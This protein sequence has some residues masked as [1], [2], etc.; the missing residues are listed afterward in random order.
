MYYV[1]IEDTYDV[2]KRAHIATGHGGRDQ[3]VREIGKKYVNVTRDAIEL[4]KSYRYECQKKHKRPRTKGVVVRPTLTN[5]FASRAQV[6]LID[7]QSMSQHAFKWILVY[8]DH[9]TKFVI[10]RA[11]TSKRAAEV[12]HN[13]LDIFLLIGAPSILQS[14]NGTEFTAEVITELKLFW[15]RLVMVHGKPRH[16]QS[17]GSVERAN[18]DIK[19][20]LVAWMGDNDTNDWSIGIKFVQFQKNSSFHSGIGRAPHTAMFGCD[21]KVGLATSSLPQEIIQRMQTEDDL[22]AAINAEQPIDLQDDSAAV[23]NDEVLPAAADEQIL[24]SGVPIPIEDDPVLTEDEHPANLIASRI[25]MIRT[26]RSASRSAQLQ[27]AE[28]MVKRSRLELAAGMP[29]DNV[30]IPIPLVDRGRG[31]PRNILGVIVDRDQ[32]DMYKISVK[33]GMLKARFS[34]NQFDLC[35]QKLLKESDV[36]CTQEVSLRQAVTK[37]SK[38]GGQGLFVAIVPG[39][40]VVKVIV[41]SATKAR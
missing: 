6:D 33:S 8:Q 11:L 41:V 35:P 18:G 13:L 19:D 40:D 9:L 25:D 3:M 12:A 10:L 36:N 7:M 34:R 1:S 4:F 24:P 5:E 30:A 37:E 38:S 16:P 15:P 22:L 14:D 31:D 29:G 23:T 26:E 28:R 39:T 21:A 27:Q 32:N 20:M 2:I 17:Q